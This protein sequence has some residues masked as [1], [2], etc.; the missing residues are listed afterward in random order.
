MNIHKSLAVVA[1]VIASTSAHA[2]DEN[3]R[4]LR[5]E[6]ENLSPFKE[7]GQYRT[8]IYKL[9]EQ[10][11]FGEECHAIHHSLKDCHD[12][13]DKFWS[14]CKSDARKRFHIYVSR[15][16]GIDARRIVEAEHAE[17][18]KRRLAAVEAAKE[19]AREEAKPKPRF[20]SGSWNMDDYHDEFKGDIKKS[21][22]VGS[23]MYTTQYSLSVPTIE[24]VSVDGGKSY[25]YIYVG[26]HICDFAVTGK[27]IVD[28]G[29]PKKIEFSVSNDNEALHFDKDWYWIKKFNDGDL[30]KIRFTDGCGQETRLRFNITGH[31]RF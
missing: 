21:Y 28:G 8:Q 14:A 24:V 4:H 2:I 25:A 13:P 16:D 31:T 18:E 5:L 15:A 23:V 30:L 9:C 12:N 6:G 27:A 11:S 10:Y 1:A 3:A 26:G 17:R 20:T 22:L 7:L 29:K 19:Q